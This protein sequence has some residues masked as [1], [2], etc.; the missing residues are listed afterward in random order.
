MF[1]LL[2]ISLVGWFW[3]D[4]L[5]TQ[6]VAKTICKQICNQFQLQLLDDAIA[7]AHIRIK[8]NRHRRWIIQRTYYFE[9]CDDGNSRQRGI[10]S[11]HGLTLEILELPGHVNRIISLV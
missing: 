11:M 5:R 3:F 7:L 6:E 8:R 1:I 9:F 10:L 2:L 4:N